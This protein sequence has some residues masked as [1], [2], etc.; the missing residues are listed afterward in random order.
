M[1]RKIYSVIKATGSYIPTKI[2]KNEDF[3]KNEFFD[4][5]GIKINL[6]PEEIIRKFEE[7]T[8]IKE[9]RYVEEDQVASD[10]AYLSALDA[11]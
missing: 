1:T 6:S 2:V 11:L 5:Q 7:I 10:L 3:L 9:R 4:P 8:E